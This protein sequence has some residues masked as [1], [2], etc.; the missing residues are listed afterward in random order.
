MSD[1]N[2][3]SSIKGGKKLKDETIKH[4]VI[5]GGSING[6]FMYGALKES[7]QQQPP[8]WTH[9]KLTSIYATSVGTMIATMICLGFDWETLD[10]YI[11]HRPWK[12]VF[13]ITGELLFSS[14]SKKGLFDADLIIEIFRPLLLA[15]NLSLTI[16]FAEL[17]V[18]YPIEL[19]FYSFDINAFEQI[20]ISRETF[21][22]LPVLTGISMSSALPGFFAPV[23]IPPDSPHYADNR[24]KCFI[25]GG[26][27]LNY[28]IFKCLEK[29]PNDHEIL[30][31]TIQTIN[32]PFYKDNDTNITA[33]S[34]ILEYFIGFANKIA[35][36]LVKI[37]PCPTILYEI[38]CSSCA[39][40]FDFNKC[41][42]II[43]SS[44]MRQ[45][46]IEHGMQDAKKQLKLML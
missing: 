34:N 10:K 22:D 4:L 6:L 32:D 31:I 25:D 29:F 44:E 33:N 41:S 17:Y 28:P 23:F 2:T 39:T 40:M 11:I 30:G 46:W 16:T 36:Y 8:V 13:T 27:R 18:Q 3:S 43:H 20:D 45:Q 7:N 38:K 26:I 9:D 15:K 19:H 35:D 1:N 21:P 5:S 14:Y 42:D 37:V 12:N 24:N